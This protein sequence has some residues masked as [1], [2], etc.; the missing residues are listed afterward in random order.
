MNVFFDIGTNNFQGY[1]ELA[2]TLNIDESWHKIFVEPNPNFLNN[3]DW[4]TKL[5]SIKNSNLVSGA[6]CCN[7]SNKTAEL[8]F[9]E[10]FNDLDQGASIF[11]DVW[12]KNNIVK[13]TISVNTFSFDEIA[14]KYLNEDWYIKMDCENCEYYCL[15]DMIEK[16]HE[17][18]KYIVCEFH[19]PVPEG[20]EH[21]KEEIFNL[22]KKYNVKLKEW[23]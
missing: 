2:K 1:D 11:N 17:N 12:K 19:Y 8:M 22:A 7:C 20:H 4:I 3:E 18:I 6:L 9:I 10:G 5:S 14:K 15:K 23:K 21:Y 16:Y 13:K